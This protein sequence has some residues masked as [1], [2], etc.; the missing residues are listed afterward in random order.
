ETVAAVGRTRRATR[1]QDLGPADVRVA[2]A[3]RHVPPILRAETGRAGAASRRAGIAAA[4]LVADA[5]ASA[6]GR[7]AGG[8]TP[9]DA[10]MR[11]AR[12]RPTA[13]HEARAA[14][15]R[16]GGT[17]HEPASTRGT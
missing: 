8:G 14:A 12:A 15:R 17:A 5:R 4:R 11:L 13:R 6:S 16:A 1:G 7:P 10:A 9:L 3:R 2:G